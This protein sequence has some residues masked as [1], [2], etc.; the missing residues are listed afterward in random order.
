[1]LGACDPGLI[2]LFDASLLEPF[3]EGADVDAEVLRDL[4]ARDSRVAVQHD[5]HDVVTV[6]GRY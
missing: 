6:L 3:I 1:M 2:A 5:A 4:R